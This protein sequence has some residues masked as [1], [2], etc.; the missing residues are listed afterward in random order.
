M[1]LKLD[2]AKSEL[3]F[4]TMNGTSN[5]DPKD[6]VFGEKLGSVGQGG[7]HTPETNATTVNTAP[8]HF[9]VFSSRRRHCF[10]GGSNCTW[11]TVDLRRGF[12][13]LDDC[14]TVVLG[15][16]GQPRACAHTAA[17]SEMP[18]ARSEEECLNP[19]S[20]AGQERLR[21]EASPRAITARGSPPGP[22]R[23]GP[24]CAAMRQPVGAGRG[25][26]E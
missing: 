15:R 3:L 26:R 19:G 2:R 24:S 11:R 17:A 8:V 23:R 12:P 25:H 10:C 9:A 7:P 5:A 21:S 6:A 14:L 13:L 1:I 20:S 4:S 16:V 18:L 22:A